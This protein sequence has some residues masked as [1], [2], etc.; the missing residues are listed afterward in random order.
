MASSGDKTGD[1]LVI[2]GITGD[3][4]RKMTFRA[5]YR[6]EQRGLLS[7]PIIGVARADISAEEL[8]ARAHDA[9]VQSGEDVDRHVFGRLARRISYV[10]GDVTQSGV[11]GELAAKMGNSR[12]PVFYLEMP[13]ELYAPIVDHLGAASLLRD[14]R[15]ALEK[16][17]GHD[18]ASARELNAKLHRMLRDDQILRVDHFLGKEP[19]IG[20]EYLRFA[21]F[22]LAE[23]WDRRSVTATLRLEIDNWRWADVPVFI[24]AGKQLPERVTEVRLLLRRTPRLAFLSLPTRAEPNQIVVRIDPDP[25]MRLELVALARDT[26][27]PV[28]LDASFTRELGPPMEP[29]ER[30]LY[31]AIVDDHQL[32]PREDNV[33]ETWRIVQPLLDSPPDIQL[34]PPG[35]WGPAAADTLVRGYS[36]W[37]QPWLS[38]DRRGTGP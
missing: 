32:F 35:S 24:R 10:H 21:N 8:V 22:A 4:A 34:Y 37:Q 1:L 2:F 3:L 27:R 7:F 16:P 36:S 12:R 15:V 14:G 29:Y 25:G 6:L 17:F 30:L 33:E 20:L 19:V 9:I 5:L 26:W 23:L 11:Y 28:H 38:E 13:P 31:A 18:L